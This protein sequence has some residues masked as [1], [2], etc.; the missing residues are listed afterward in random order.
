H[1]DRAAHAIGAELA[2]AVRRG[3]D[4]AEPVG[5]PALRVAG[6]AVMLP[7]PRLSVK[8]C[9]GG[10]APA[11]L[12]VPLRSVFPRQTALTAVAGGDAAG[13]RRLLAGRRVAVE[14]ALADGLVELAD[15]VGDGGAHL[16]ALAAARELDGGA[17]LGTDAAI[18]DA[19]A[20]VLAHPLLGRLR[21]RQLGTPSLGSSSVGR[22]DRR[23]SC[24]IG[25]GFS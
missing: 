15:G 24:R 23:E 25:G 3:W 19:A 22:A 20:L 7:P 11:A 21:V 14:H 5:P 4:A 6:R 13:E 16:G 12:T 8:N 9:V 18:A 2:A 10:W 1:G 17:D